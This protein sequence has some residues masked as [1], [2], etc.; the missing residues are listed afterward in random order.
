MSL[1]LYIM[2]YLMDYA[3]LALHLESVH[4]VEALE[5]ERAGQANYGKEL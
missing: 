1:H 2:L 4:V 5:G 3:H